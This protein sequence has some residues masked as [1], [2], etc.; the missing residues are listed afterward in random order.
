MARVRAATAQARRLP[1]FSAPRS[2]LSAPRSPLPA[3]SA[4]LLARFS[5][6]L[7]ALGG[8][9]SIVRADQAAQ[10]IL[11]ILEEKN[12]ARLLAWS[13]ESLPA[14]GLYEIL[15]R[16]GITVFGP[17]VS[18]NDGE[19]GLADRAAAEVG[20]TGCEA[21]LAETGSLVMRAAPG[22]GRLASLLPPV[23]IA[24]LRPEQIFPSLQAYLLHTR[25]NGATG[26]LF[27][28]SSN[29]TL[30]TGPS[31]TADIEMTLTIGV[32]GPGELR[33]LCLTD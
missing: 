32:H 3:S 17:M 1:A 16:A 12:A 28:E 13:P 7:T 22:R 30:I 6:E 24:L 10:A 33:V 19:A 18:G 15:R 8:T 29:L 11:A 9:F 23:H 5:D 26:A 31:R 27:G 21:A 2:P 14:P 20:L 4:A 25:Q